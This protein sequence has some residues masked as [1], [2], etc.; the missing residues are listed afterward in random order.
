MNIDKYIT[1]NMENFQKEHLK[2]FFL[3]IN[4]MKKTKSFLVLTLLSTNISI[5][6]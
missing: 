4:K 1:F 2:Y 5:D 3:F 6:L